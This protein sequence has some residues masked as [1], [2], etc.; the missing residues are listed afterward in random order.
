M[1]KKLSSLG[2]SLVVTV[3]TVVCSPL[4]ADHHTSNEALGT[5]AVGIINLVAQDPSSYVAS[6]K[7]NGEIFEQLGVTIAGACTAVSGNQ[8]PGEMQFFSF[9]PSVAD[10][11][12]V[13]DTMIGSAS[14]R[15]LQE[16]LSDNRTLAGNETW[17]IIDGYG[18]EIRDTWATR[19]VEVNPT[20]VQQYIAAIKNLESAYHENG[21]DDIE[22]DVYQPIGSGSQ[23]LLNVVAV[24][25]TLYRLGEVFDV[26]NSESWSE[27]AY[28]LV[29]ASRPALVSDKIYKCEQ[30]YSSI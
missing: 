11:M 18:G 25:P 9:V 6:Q 29:T 30:V 4:L 28:A 21:Y 16:E 12:Q 24:A 10:A 5:G 2:R 14:I 22:F 13:W 26:L 17:Q 23:P 3:L 7:L 27:Q 20:D 8:V 1:M 15:Q 19:L